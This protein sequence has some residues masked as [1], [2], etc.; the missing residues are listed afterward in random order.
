MAR[1]RSSCRACVATGWSRKVNVSR[2]PAPPRSRVADYAMRNVQ[3]TA[4]YRNQRKEALRR[5]RLRR[6]P[7][8]P[9]GKGYSQRRA[10]G[11]AVP[12]LLGCFTWTRLQSFHATQPSLYAL[13]ETAQSPARARRRARA[14]AHAPPS[15]SLA[16]RRCKGTSSSSRAS[17]A[18]PYRANTPLQPP[19]SSTPARSAP[20]SHGVAAASSMPVGLDSCAQPRRRDACRGFQPAGAYAYLRAPVGG[21]AGAAIH[22]VGVWP[23]WPTQVEHHTRARA[24]ADAEP[25]R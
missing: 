18:R 21:S 1:P 12:V 4:T 11:C 9:H 25:A 3:H 19:L 14:R 10:A 2:G 13:T 6:E 22:R 5:P 16:S 20:S 15:A 23:G 17:A 8:V 7:G 24:C